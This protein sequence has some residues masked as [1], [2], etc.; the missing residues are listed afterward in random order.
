MLTKMNKRF[1]GDM[2]ISEVIKLAEKIGKSGSY[3]KNVHIEYG[4]YKKGNMYG[5]IYG[6]GWC[7]TGLGEEYC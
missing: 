2:P 3:G 4:F 6:T 1:S 7:N 5:A